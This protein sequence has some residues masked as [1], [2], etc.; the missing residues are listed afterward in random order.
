MRHLNPPHYIYIY[1]TAMNQLILINSYLI[2]KTLKR[3]VIVFLK[4]KWSRNSNGN[5]HWCQSDKVKRRFEVW[6]KT[7][8]LQYSSSFSQNDN[9]LLLF[10]FLVTGLQPYTTYRFSDCLITW[11]KCFLTSLNLGNWLEDVWWWTLSSEQLIVNEMTYLFFQF[12]RGR[13]ERHRNVQAKQGE[14]S[15][16]D[17]QR[18]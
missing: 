3:E 17:A 4:E 8:Y 5:Q 15:N 18:K 13:W 6:C 7:E 10:R 9:T 12:P 16:H 1:N 14:L 2:S 11:Y